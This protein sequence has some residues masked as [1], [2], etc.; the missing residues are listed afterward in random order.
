MIFIFKKIFQITIHETID[1]SPKVH[2]RVQSPM[3]SVSIYFFLILFSFRKK[4]SVEKL[5]QNKYIFLYLTFVH[6]KLWTHAMPH[7]FQY[8]M[9][10]IQNESVFL[11]NCNY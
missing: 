7:V 3:L 4:K 10:S 8:A 6:K 1:A 5:E 9:I 11:Y 2:D